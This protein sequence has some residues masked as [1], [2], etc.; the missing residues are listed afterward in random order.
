MNDLLEGNFVELWAVFA[1][2]ECQHNNE[3]KFL[4]PK[5]VT[6]EDNNH[7][8][9]TVL[10][11]LVVDGSPVWTP[12]EVQQD[13]NWTPTGLRNG[14]LT[15]LQQDFHGTP[16]MEHAVKFKKVKYIR[17]FTGLPLDLHWTLGECKVMVDGMHKNDSAKHVAPPGECQSIGKAVRMN[18]IKV[19]VRAHTNSSRNPE[20]YSTKSDFQAVFTCNV[21]KIAAIYCTQLK[22]E[23]M[24][25][26]VV[27]SKNPLTKLGT[28]WLLICQGVHGIGVLILL[29]SAPAL[30]TSVLLVGV[31]N[32]CL[33][34]FMDTI[35]IASVKLKSA[36]SVLHDSTITMH[37]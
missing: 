31:A 6:R 30:T 27:R 24:F 32:K 8:G 29:G 21:L 25:A 19:F 4:L 34:F 26:M 36:G 20:A 12:A 22:A 18:F 2:F 17:T 35:V 9:A 11:C 3:Q 14:T 7:I 28:Q 23:S 13:S 15:G 1:S 37:E 10:S 16:I 33:I 5:E